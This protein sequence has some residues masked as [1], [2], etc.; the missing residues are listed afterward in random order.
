MVTCVILYSKLYDNCTGGTDDYDL[1]PFF[2]RFP[3]KTRC[4]DSLFAKCAPFIVEIRDDNV[5]EGNENF[6][7]TIQA[8]LPANI[9]IAEPSQTTVTI[10]DND[11]E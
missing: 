6:I 4:N 5:Y 1:G 9:T 3:P 10:V 8:S 7:L 11:R 2:I